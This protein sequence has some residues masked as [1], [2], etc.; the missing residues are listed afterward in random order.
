M[1]A[2]S[3]AQ[4]AAA[5]STASGSAER[6]NDLDVMEP[7]GTVALPGA[8]AVGRD[9]RPGRDR[10]VAHAVRVRLVEAVAGAVAF[11][12]AEP[13]VAERGAGRR[14]HAAAVRAGRRQR[15]R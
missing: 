2:R 9:R 13:D 6:E 5:T 1:G 10:R 15:R 11:L 12:R 8:E 14:V 3:E 7:P 4:P